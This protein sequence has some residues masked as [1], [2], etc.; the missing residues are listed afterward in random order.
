M[1]IEH[2]PVTIIMPVRNEA[3]FIRRSLEAVLAQDYPAQCMEI[4]VAD[5]M[6]DDGTREIIRSLQQKHPNLRLVD[7]PQQIVPT[8]LNTAIR[9]ARGDVIIRIDGHALVEPDYVR[10]C[11]E[12]LQKTGADCVGGA[13][14]S[15]GEGYV[16]QSIAFAMSSPLGVG[17][18]AFRN[19]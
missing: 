15:I 5:G 10:T 3:S 14:E 8:G 7:N 18:S 11:V 1:G 2:L 4:I 6:S 19:A 17:G 9:H 13:I 16:G 12:W